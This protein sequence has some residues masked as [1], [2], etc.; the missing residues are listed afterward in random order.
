MHDANLWGRTTIGQ[1]CEAG[2]LAPYAL[3]G[4]AAYPCCLWMLSPFKGHKDRLLREEYYWNYVQSSIR[5]C[6]ERAFGLLKGRWKILLKRIDVQL[7][8]VPNLV[9]TCLVLYNICTIFGDKF[10]EQEW[11]REACTEIHDSLTV[12][13]IPGN[14]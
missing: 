7:A 2:R 13:R 3:V 10:E 1:F 5:M 8:N 4:D 12:E 6:I 11:L 14:S 9:S